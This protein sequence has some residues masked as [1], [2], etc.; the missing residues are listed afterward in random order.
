MLKIHQIFIIKF[1]ALFVGALLVTS[2]ISYMALRSVIIGN[3]KNHLE[4]SI[5]LMELELD[6]IVNLDKFIAKVHDKTSLRITIV[7]AEGVVIAE[8]NTD[9]NSMDNH[10]NRYEIM[11]ANSE[12]FAD[13]TRYSK[14]LKVDF[15]YVAKKTQ[16]NNETIYIRLSMSLAQIM[17][18]FYSLWIK[19]FFVF[20]GI[21]LIATFIS[22][23]M[24]ERVVYDI[25]QITNYLDEISNKNYNAAIKIEYFYEFLQI[26]LLLK[27]L[28]KKLAKN[29]KKKIKNIAKLRLINKQRNDILSA[30]SHEFKNPIA[31]IMGYAQTIREDADM[32][33]KIRDKFLEK[34][35]SN[36]DKISKMLDRLA[37]SVKLDNGDLTINNSE[38][39]LKDLCNEVSFNQ[40]SKYKDRDIIVEADEV[41]VFSDK[42]M[43]ELVLINLVDNAMK[44]SSGDVKIILKDEKISIQDSGIGIKE[45]HL[46]KVTSKFYRVDKNSW[47]N[48]MGIGLAMVSYILKSLNSNLEIESEFAKGSVFSFSI[49]EMLKS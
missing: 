6:K 25:S 48:S 7:N 16:F 42:T 33:P 23:K 35:S 45:E 8:S 31:S 27:N 44:Y 15:L 9:K 41:I 47:D 4:H 29:D 49:K 18:D 12:K 17:D 3:N 37:L 28:V 10:G 26:S 2:L 11:K 24:S 46:D 20:I 5:D 34:I 39:D 36:G 30:L 21:I 19:L 38:F 14:T 40:S 32:P 13:I 22:K 1:L 43:L